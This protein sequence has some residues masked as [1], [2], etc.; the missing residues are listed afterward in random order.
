MIFQSGH[1][2]LSRQLFVKLILSSESFFGTKKEIDR[3]ANTG[4]SITT[5]FPVLKLKNILSLSIPFSSS[6]FSDQ[7]ARS[8]TRIAKEE[9][10]IQG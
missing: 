2:T 10:R 1:N 5:T 3:N 8:R 9:A 6:S 4:K 7:V